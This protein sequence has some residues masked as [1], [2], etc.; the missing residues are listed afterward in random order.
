ML[1]TYF[2]IEKLITTITITK[3]KAKRDQVNMSYTK[4]GA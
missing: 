2:R 1:R 4:H 3:W